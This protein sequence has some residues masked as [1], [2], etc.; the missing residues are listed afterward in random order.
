MWFSR[1]QRT[2][3]HEHLFLFFSSINI[4]KGDLELIAQDTGFDSDQQQPC[5]L[6]V[7]VESIIIILS[8][9]W[10]SESTRQDLAD[11]HRDR[12]PRNTG[13]RKDHCM[14]SGGS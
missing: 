1:I 8:F 5:N 4:F 10:P 13:T 6:D 9:P 14:V 3:K 2:C 7:L 11:S 12:N